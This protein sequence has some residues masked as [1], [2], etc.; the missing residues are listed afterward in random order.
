MFI[1]VHELALHKIPIRKSYT[2]GTLDFH[3]N[4]F[5]QVE[6]LEVR[7]TAELVDDQIRIHG[8]IHTRLELICARCLDTVM[9]EISKDVDLFYRRTTALPADDEDARLNLDDTE[10]GFF[11]GD[12]LFLADV[13]AEQVNLALPMKV[14]CRSDCRGLCTQCGANLNHDECR[15]ET[16]SADSRSTPLG[17][18]KQDWLKK[19]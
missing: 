10:I 4:D 15:C 8:T 7:A 1:D 17:R 18:L 13:L 2:P 14:I 16:H 5:R 3:S 9:E 12:G 11:E 19:Q 6:P